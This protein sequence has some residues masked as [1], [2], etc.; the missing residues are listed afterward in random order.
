MSKFINLKT[1]AD[2]PLFIDASTITAIEIYEDPYSG[3]RLQ[4]KQGEIFNISAEKWGVNLQDVLK[5][6]ED[7]GYPLVAI[8]GK[9]GDRQYDGYLSPAAVTSITVSKTRDDGTVTSN[10]G[11]EGVVYFEAR[12]VKHEYIDNLI[13]AT[14]ATGKKLLE[15]GPAELSGSYYRDGKVFINPDS[16]RRVEQ[17]RDE[18]HVTFENAPYFRGYLPKEDPDAPFNEALALREV[19]N[20]RELHEL[21]TEVKDR[22]AKTAAATVKSVVSKLTAGNDTLVQLPGQNIFVRPSD[23]AYV[24]KFKTDDGKFVLGLQPPRTAS[25]TFPEMVRA[26]YNTEAERDVAFE[27]FS[28]ATPSKPSV[29]APAP[30]SRPQP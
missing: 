17:M 19:N 11:L 8:P 7:A 24:Q 29:V 15:F 3:F 6:M 18:I 16:I 20:K 9:S 23:F 22:L 2:K 1:S 13:D 12:G 26:M 10:I 30:K 5:K 21:F 14:K 28:G 4:S 27:V 25:N